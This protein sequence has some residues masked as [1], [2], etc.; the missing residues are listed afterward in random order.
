MGALEREGAGSLRAI[1]QTLGMSLK[2]SQIA[3]NTP[4]DGIRFP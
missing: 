1:L 3:S 2:V 4:T